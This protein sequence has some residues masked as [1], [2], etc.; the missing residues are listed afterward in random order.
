MLYIV[1][2]CFRNDYGIITLHPMPY[3]DVR[4]VLSLIRQENG[5]ALSVKM[6]LS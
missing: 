2:A 6:T 4:L 3:I 5:I 1:W